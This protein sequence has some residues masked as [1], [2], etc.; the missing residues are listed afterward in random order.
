MYILDNALRAREAAGKP[1]RVG[2]I[3]AG[4]MARGLANQILNT[5]V[6]MRLVAIFNRTLE[7]AVRAYKEAGAECIEVTTQGGL[8]DAIRTGKYAVTSDWQ[9]LTRSDQIDILVD[10]T[11]AVEFGT[12]VVLD[13]FANGKHVVLMNA[14]LDATVGPI[15]QT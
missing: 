13:A 8:E 4:F 3:G 5:F 11:G 10:V 14:E 15:L 2:M 12:H 6:G 9:L 7:R 1:I